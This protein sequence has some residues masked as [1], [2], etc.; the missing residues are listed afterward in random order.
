MHAVAAKRGYLT[1]ED[2][3][4]AIKAGAGRFATYQTTLEA[5]QMKRAE[6]PA[7]CAYVAVHSK[8]WRTRATR[9]R[10]TTP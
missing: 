10:G 7:L 8:E 9:K 3:G 2:I 5:I 6:D 1:P 4:E